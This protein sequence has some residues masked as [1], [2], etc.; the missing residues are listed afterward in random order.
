V[1]GQSAEARAERLAKGCCPTHGIGMPQVDIWYYPPGQTR[2]QGG[3]LAEGDETFPYTI[4]G[5]PRRDCDE[6]AKAKDDFSCVALPPEQ[7][8]LYDGIA[9]DKRMKAS[10]PKRM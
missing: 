8:S 10:R 5:C 3:E 1:K 4:V 6:Y 2:W 7:H 9:F